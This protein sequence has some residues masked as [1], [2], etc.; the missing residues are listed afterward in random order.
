MVKTAMDSR[1]TR[2]GKFNIM[3]VYS[4]ETAS[5]IMSLIK[6]F[7]HIQQ[8]HQCLTKTFAL[9]GANCSYVRSWGEG[10]TSVY[11]LGVICPPPP[12]P[13]GLIPT[14]DQTDNR[15]TCTNIPQAQVKDTVHV[16]IHCH[17]FST[18]TLAQWVDKTSLTH[19]LEQV[20]THIVCTV[21]PLYSGHPWDVAN[22]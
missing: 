3:D 16:Y 6:F 18:N 10:S 20:N 13:L 22:W 14:H 17:V 11:F 1:Q 8:S 2:D 5:G 19:A 12:A 4:T 15:K 21:K 9:E 7:V